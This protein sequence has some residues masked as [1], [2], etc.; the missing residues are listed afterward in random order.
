MRFR[1]WCT[2][3]GNEVISPPGRTE[4]GLDEVR[5]LVALMSLRCRLCDGKVEVSKV[6]DAEGE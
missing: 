2:Q 3:C 1:M 4:E 5:K 6:P